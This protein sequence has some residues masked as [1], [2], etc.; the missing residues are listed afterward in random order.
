[1]VKLSIALSAN[2]NLQR[3]QIPNTNRHILI[4][5]PK[6]LSD[7]TS[8]LNSGIVFKGLPSDDVVLCTP[9][10][11]YFVREVQTS[12]TFSL[13]KQLSA[14]SFEDSVDENAEPWEI[15]NNLSSYLELSIWV[16][17]FERLHE[18]L[19]ENMIVNPDDDVI[20]I[21][22]SSDMD[23]EID[24]KVSNGL[25]TFD[26]LK[27]V[28]Q[29]SDKEI[30]DELKKFNAVGINGY[31]RLIAPSYVEYILAQI[32]QTCIQFDS[33]LDSIPVNDIVE[34]LTDISDGL[35]RHCI[36]MFSEPFIGP[37]AK[38]SESKVCKFL[39]KQL[40]LEHKSGIE[41]EK[42]ISLWQTLVPDTFSVN[43]D[44]LKG[45][46]ITE[47]STSFGSDLTII[48][49]IPCELSSDPR[50]RLEQ[51]FSIKNQWLGIHLL[52]FLSD[53]LEGTDSE[54]KKKLNA[55]LM[56]YCRRIKGTTADEDEF[57]LRKPEVS[58]NAK[59]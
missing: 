30:W 58:C 42:F 31:Q 39:G 46:A 44:E 36:E 54:M 28:V 19:R 3:S 32:I 51:L 13:A 25:Y 20:T 7:D 16:P 6:E 18:C 35:V 55:I 2:T 21:D 59:H 22:V 43:L 11:T 48:K 57:V 45:F 1:M 47:K 37:I 33:S 15:V 41:L 9:T 23:H 27:D 17:K 40:L 49:H 24:G 56:K 38:L 50:K 10:K 4:E 53:F 29:A 8:L 12:N 5:L 52:P 14:L 26:D 34:I